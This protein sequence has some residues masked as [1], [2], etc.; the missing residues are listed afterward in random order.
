MKYGY[1]QRKNGKYDMFVPHAEAHS[2]SPNV[3]DAAHCQLKDEISMNEIKSR[4][5]SA[6][7]HLT[8]G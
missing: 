1:I 2:S 3:S 8:F 7:L 4:A 5:A 6:R